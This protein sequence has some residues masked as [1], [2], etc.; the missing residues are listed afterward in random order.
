MVRGGWKRQPDGNP[1]WQEWKPDQCP[2]GHKR[3]GA[4]TWACLECNWPTRA[5]PCMTE[6]CREVIW[7]PEHVHGE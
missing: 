7:D 1:A 4:A 5:W 6:G 3:L 2:K